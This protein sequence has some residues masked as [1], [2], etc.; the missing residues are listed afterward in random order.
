MNIDEPVFSIIHNYRKPLR[1]VPDPIA[2]N[3]S[4]QFEL[5]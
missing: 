3:D 5:I 2:E 4:D 1:V